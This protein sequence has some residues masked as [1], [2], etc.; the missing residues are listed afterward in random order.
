MKY[1]MPITADTGAFLDHCLSAALAASDP[2]L[3]LSLVAKLV[4]DWQAGK[5]DTKQRQ[6]QKLLC[7]HPEKPELVPPGL[8]KH[9]GPSTPEGRAT[10]IHAIAHIE[11]SAINLAL[12]HAARFIA[13][14]DEYIADWIGVAA[15]EAYH[16]RL[17]R[18]HL[19]HL[20]YDYGSFPAHDGLWNMAEKTTEDVLARMAL[21]P[22]LLEARGLDAT[23]PIQA[24]LKQAGDHEAARLLAII[25]HDEV[26]HV[27]LGDKWFRRLCAERGLEPEATYRDILNTYQAPRPVAPMNIEA[28]LA[29]GFSEKELAE[30]LAR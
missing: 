3:K 5:F 30:L 12:D 20:G 28:R 22:R 11:F 17:L 2:E 10:L 14:P 6:R 13:M 23:P 19:R 9:R 29:A 24:K 7:G 27:G 25:L 26:G 18:D 1:T 21:V 16:F 8:V 15:E 4:D